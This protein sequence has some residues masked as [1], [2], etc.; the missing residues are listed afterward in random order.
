M[1]GPQRLEEDIR[2]PE[3]ELRMTVGLR[4]GSGNPT[5]P[6]FCESTK[7][8]TAELS[9]ALGGTIRSNFQ[10]SSPNLN[11]DSYYL[12]YGAKVGVRKIIRA[13][14]GS[15]TESLPTMPKAGPGLPG[16]GHI[17]GDTQC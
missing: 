4:K 9:L 13:G 14:R 8:S 15:V 3:Q 11:K 16:E 10:S 6:V 5:L 12:P 17:Q 1:Q 7:C 2:C